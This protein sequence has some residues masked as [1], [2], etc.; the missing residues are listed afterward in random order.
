MQSKPFLKAIKNRNNKNLHC[1]KR[2]NT[3]RLGDLRQGWSWEGGVSSSGRA[4]WYKGLLARKGPSRRCLHCSVLGSWASPCSACCWSLLV[5]GDSTHSRGGG[6]GGWGA[7]YLFPKLSCCVD[8][9]WPGLPV[10]HYSAPCRSLQWLNPLERW[11]QPEG[12]G[13]PSWVAGRGGKLDVHKLG[14]S[15]TDVCA[16]LDT[17]YG[18]GSALLCPSDQIIVISHICTPLHTF[19]GLSWWLSQ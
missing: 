14:S 5:S 11:L 15:W 17:N 18:N 1:Q 3:K 6:E 2:G 7:L 4:N 13:R 16:T 19:R 12:C 8:R 9:P 10:P